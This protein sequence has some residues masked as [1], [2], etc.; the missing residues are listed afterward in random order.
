MKKPLNCGFFVLII[1][2]VFHAMVSSCC[3]LSKLNEELVAE[4]NKEDKSTGL[5]RE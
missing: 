2:V 1:A 4:V 5:F 3:F